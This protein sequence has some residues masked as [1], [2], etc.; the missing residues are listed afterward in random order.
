[1]AAIFAAL[2]ARS[3]VQPAAQLMTRKGSATNS[4]YSS[5]KSNFT[6]MKRDATAVPTATSRLIHHGERS[7]TANSEFSCIFMTGKR[8]RQ[9]KRASPFFDPLYF[10]GA[11]SSR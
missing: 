5:G 1:P 6:S 10:N 2:G 4:A 3:C 11:G 7:S 8:G 9:E